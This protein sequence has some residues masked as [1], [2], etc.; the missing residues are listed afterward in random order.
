MT[1]SP[2]ALQGLGTSGLS[3]YVLPRG[4]PVHP[5]FPTLIPFRSHP[6]VEM[7]REGGREL[8]SWHAEAPFLLLPLCSGPDEVNEAPIPAPRHEDQTPVLS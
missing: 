3:S 8:E 7:G 4:C 1:F 5:H 6:R 2:M